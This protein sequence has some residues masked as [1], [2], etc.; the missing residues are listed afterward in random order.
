MKFE[1]KKSYLKS[2]FEKVAEV[3]TKAIKADF[4][5]ANRACIIAEDNRLTFCATN[6]HID[7]RRVIEANDENG[8]K[9]K[10]TGKIIAQSAASLPVAKAIGGSNSDALIEVYDENDSLVFR[11]TGAK[12]K[13]N[14]SVETFQSC[15]DVEVE[16][17]EKPAYQ[18]SFDV[19]SF[20][21]W[22]KSVLPLT[23]K[24]G[25]KVKYQMLCMHLLK[26]GTRLICGDGSRFGICSTPEKSSKEAKLIL[27]EDQVAIILS[28][29]AESE[30]VSFLWQ[31][32]QCC[33]ISTSDGHEMVLRGI[34][35]IDYIA[36]DIH[37]F[38]ENEAKYVVDI[39]IKNF[40]D[41]I[42]LTGAVRDEELE[43]SGGFF[44]SAVLNVSCK[45][46][47][48][49]MQVVERR[50]ADIEFD[51]QVY[52]ND[53]GADDEFKAVY[54]HLFLSESSRLNSDFIRFYY[55]HKNGVMI[56]RPVS[57]GDN[58][59]DKGVPIP[60]ETADK[61]EFRMFF[62]SVKEKTSDE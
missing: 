23:S 13:E 50:K 53:A 8:L 27:P 58:K 20:T 14:A 12:Y 5:Q 30:K 57:V 34:P 17:P 32:K 59:D 9:V 33:Y 31:D 52:K 61:S 43:K 21:K 4:D 40:Y 24:R 38:K 62:A 28:V 47:R 42:M 7:Y 19:A 35:D 55:L 46:N 44:H 36:Y 2:L 29:I 1:L 48:C 54:A 22:A 26:E 56:V 25:Y 11:N 45:T 51:I 41:A 39:P 49:D 37:A 3:S 6:G 16:K 60:L 15:K 10:Q 18:V